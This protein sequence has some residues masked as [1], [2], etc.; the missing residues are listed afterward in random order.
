MSSVAET[1]IIPIQDFL[2]QD[3][4][5]RINTPSTLG[6]NWTYRVTREMLSAGLADRIGAVTHIYRRG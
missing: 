4:K 2:G 6:G 1:V 5:S 3:G